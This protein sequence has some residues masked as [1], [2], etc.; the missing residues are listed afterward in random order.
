MEETFRKFRSRLLDLGHYLRKA[1]AREGYGSTISV[2]EHVTEMYS[3]FDKVG[4]FQPQTQVENLDFVRFGML[5]AVYSIV[6]EAVTTIQ[7]EKRF[8]RTVWT[9]RAIIRRFVSPA[10]ST[11][12]KALL[13]SDFDDFQESTHLVNRFASGQR[14]YSSV[15]S[16]T[17]WFT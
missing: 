7:S 12:G 6:P 2:Q 16:I 8:E 4:L 13:M 3:G 10:Y 17:A 9:L 14:F 5:Q 15:I 1:Y 11:I